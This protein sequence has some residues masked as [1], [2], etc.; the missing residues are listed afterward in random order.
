ME[1]S[2]GSAG[3]GRPS[4]LF[5]QGGST[6]KGR[7]DAKDI[8]DTTIHSPT[9]TARR[10]IDNLLP[11]WTELK[12]KI[13]ILYLRLHQLLLNDMVVLYQLSYLHV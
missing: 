2:T 9:E 10:S 1:T 13:W 3:I 12:T 8:L 6:L 7:R 11:A 5:V 4:A